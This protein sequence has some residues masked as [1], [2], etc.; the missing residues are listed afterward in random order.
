MTSKLTSGAFFSLPLSSYWPGSDLHK[1]FTVDLIKQF[2]KDFAYDYTS[3]LEPVIDSAME[4]VNR[5]NH[6]EVWNR[7][8]RIFSDIIMN[9]PD[10]V[11]VNHYYQSNG[12]VYYYQFIPQPSFPNLGFEWA[13]GATHGDEIWFV[14]G[15][16]LIAPSLYTKEEIELSKFIMRSWTEF[17]KTGLVLQIF[18]YL[19]YIQ[20]LLFMIENLQMTTYGAN[21]KLIIENIWQ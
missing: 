9:C 5:S 1:N 3:I 6:E 21:I 12:T 8:I 11:F 2:V 18:D 19:Y 13:N 10:Y 20:N 4:G 14:F 7:F 15:L 16:P 17:A